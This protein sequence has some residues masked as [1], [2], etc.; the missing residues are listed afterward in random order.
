MLGWWSFEQRCVTRNLKFKLNSW[1][2]HSGFVGRGTC[3][4]Q[5]HVIERFLPSSSLFLP[6]FL[7]A[8]PRSSI[9]SIHSAELENAPH[10]RATA[11]RTPRQR[12]WTRQWIPVAFGRPRTNSPWSSCCSAL[13]RN[14]KS[15]S[16]PEKKVCRRPR[17]PS[18]HVS[19]CCPDSVGC[20]IFVCCWRVAY[21]SG[22]EVCVR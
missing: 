14:C 18:R 21:R 12:A 5:N 10:V 15:S 9:H 8:P 2:C 7:R 11:H 6:R 4:N 3:K 1:F 17:P 13:H 22:G 20:L 16:R 19:G